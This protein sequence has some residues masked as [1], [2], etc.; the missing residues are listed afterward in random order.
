MKFQYTQLGQQCHC[1]NLL[2][3]IV[4]KSANSRELKSGCQLYSFLN[5][6]KTEQLTTKYPRYVNIG[7]KI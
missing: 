2:P 4:L 6:L 5:Q 7:I 3:Q 1:L